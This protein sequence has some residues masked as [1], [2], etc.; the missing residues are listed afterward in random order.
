LPVID[1]PKLLRLRRTVRI[2]GCILE[3]YQWSA[4]EERITIKPDE[5][6]CPAMRKL[7]NGDGKSAGMIGLDIPGLRAGPDRQTDGDGHNTGSKKEKPKP[8]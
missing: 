7:A 4:Q 8:R 1:L 6:D 5:L 2:Q 3:D